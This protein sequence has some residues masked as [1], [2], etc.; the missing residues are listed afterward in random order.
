MNF[1]NVV[2]L[3]WDSSGCSSAKW[4]NQF[5]RNA[6]PSP[7]RCERIAEEE[8]E[9]NNNGESTEEEQRCLTSNFIK[10]DH[11]QL[12]IDPFLVLI[13]RRHTPFKVP[14]GQFRRRTP[15]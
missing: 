9:K 1:L 10:R 3:S 7:T 6:E 12:F 11:L 15:W 14:I 4:D 2:K 8:D 13:G 5:L